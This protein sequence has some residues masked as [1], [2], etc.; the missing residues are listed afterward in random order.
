MKQKIIFI[1]VTVLL[2]L[3]A[4]VLAMSW[5]FRASGTVTNCVDHDGGLNGTV[6]SNV[7]HIKGI[8]V[9]SC[10]DVDVVKEYICNGTTQYQQW[11]GNC[12]ASGY[13]GCSAGRC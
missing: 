1:F 11:E 4:M 10:L 7:T 8:F 12:T 3:S 9:D 13:N 5:T 2:V 6:A